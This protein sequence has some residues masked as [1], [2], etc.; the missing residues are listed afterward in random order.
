MFGF[1]IVAML[2]MFL[3]ALLFI[4]LVVVLI[5]LLIRWLGQR[6]PTTSAPAPGQFPYSQ[7]KQ[8]YEQPQAQYQR[9]EQSPR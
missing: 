2:W 7:P 6:T 3:G 1:G 8:E 9:E 4:A 5:W